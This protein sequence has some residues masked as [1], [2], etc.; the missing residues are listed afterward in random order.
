MAKNSE[1]K[2]PGHIDLPRLFE[3]EALSLLEAV[4][5]GKLLH[6]TKNIRDSGGPLEERLR[7][8]LGSRMPSG[9]EVQTGYLYDVDSNCTPQID[10]MLLSSQDNHTMMT[11]DN[12]CIYGPFTSC[13]AAIEVKSAVGNLSAQLDQVHAIEKS[14]RE[15]KKQ[16]VSRRASSGARLPE[17]VTVLFF[18]TSETLKLAEL[19]KWYDANLSKAPTYVV[20]LDRACIVT[21]E[22]QMKQFMEMSD[23]PAVGFDEHRNPGL[24]C[25]CGPEN[26]DSLGRGRVLMWLYFTLL[27]AATM[28]GGNLR[29]ASEF[30]SDAA[31][32]FAL[33]RVVLLKDA[34]AWPARFA[35]AAKPRTK[36]S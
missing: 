29:P 12:G 10:A 24:A 17:L 25:L 20:L 8:L 19:R 16:L 21:R 11:V 22:A 36:V 26:G 28:F 15:M 35:L 18:A 4:A 34:Q 2:P 14:V 3:A 30:V 9:I 31:R 32:R 7:E 13:L 23:A 1:K 5:R 27:N 6:A 33:H